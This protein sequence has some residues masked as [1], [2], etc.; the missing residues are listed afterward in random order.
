MLHIFAILMLLL[1][2]LFITPEQAMGGVVAKGVA[3]GA[4]R[5]V[6][7]VP[8]GFVGTR[9]STVSSGGWGGTTWTFF[10]DFVAEGGNVRYF[11]VRRFASNMDMS[12]IKP[13]LWDSDGALI[14][15]M[16]TCGSTEVS[17]DLF[18]YDLGSEITLTNGATYWLG[19]ASGDSDFQISYC[20]ESGSVYTDKTNYGA[21]SCPVTVESTITNDDTQT[22]GGKY[23]I[24]MSNNGSET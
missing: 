23:P 5:V 22:A 21:S 4:P 17:T 10:S 8:D 12:W 11:Y 7:V 18:L 6:A 14:I 19:F 2:G 1:N 9:N 3:F 13:A 15:S 24:W 16:T 20:G